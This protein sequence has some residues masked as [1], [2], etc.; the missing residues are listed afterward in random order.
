MKGMK[1]MS[2]M[3][4]MSLKLGKVAHVVSSQKQMSAI[5]NAFTTLMPIIITGSFAVLLKSVILD[6]KTGLAAIPMFSFLAALQPIAAAIQYATINFMTIGAIFFISSELGRANGQK[7]NLTGFIGIVSYI[8]VLPTVTSIEVGGNMH[9]VVN[10]L[11]RDFTDAKS[12]FLGMIIA[13]IASELYCKLFTVDW[14]KVKM[15]DTVPQNVANSFSALFPAIITVFTV[16]TF[17]FFFKMLTGIYLHEAI[18]SIVQKPLEG[19]MQ[20]LPGILI[21]MLVAQI[22]WVIGVHGNQ[23][24]KP[25]REPILLAAI[26]ANADGAQNIITMPFWDMYMSIGGSGVTIGLLI[27]IFLVSKRAD[28]RAVAKLSFMPG[29]FNINETL[30]F[31]LPIMLNPIM[32][33]PFIITPLITGTI[34]YFATLWGFA[35]V[36]VNVIPWTTPPII[37]AWIATNGNMGAVITQIICII[38]AVC[39]YLPFVIISNKTSAAEQPENNEVTA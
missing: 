32:A 29:I 17:G 19:V 28:H 34:G 23:M 37:S 7:G 1:K 25:I 33:I 22:F 38:V 14:L 4:K 3:D 8:T 20:G 18:Y 21:L 13:I 5:K 10:V 16:A 31:G 27:A 6:P 2:F 35:A 39:I 11:I 9:E 26:A 30:T 15:P 36:A 12:L 24:I